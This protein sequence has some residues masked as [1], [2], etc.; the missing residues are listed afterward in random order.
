LTCKLG[1]LGEHDAIALINLETS[2]IKIVCREARFV[3]S[4]GTELI[5]THMEGAGEGISAEVS[6]LFA[7]FYIQNP[8]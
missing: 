3:S 2:D 6:V 7:K 4:S 5:A 8:F 1:R